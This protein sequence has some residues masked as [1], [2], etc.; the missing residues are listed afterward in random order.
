MFSRRGTQLDPGREKK[1]VAFT[2]VM[3]AVFLTGLKLG[4]GI[5]TG[6]LGI[7]SEAAHSGID[8]VAALLTYLAVRYSGKP[9][10][11]EH[12][13]GH[14]KIENLSALIETLLLVLTCIWIIYEA[15]HR[16]LFPKPVAANVYGFAVIFT[17]II[18]DFSRSRALSR[19]AKKYRSQ[20]LEADA[21]HFAS[22]IW[23]SLVVIVGLI[24]VK[25]GIPIGDPLAALVVAGMVIVICFRLGKKTVDVLLDRAPKGLV[26]E[27]SAAARKVPGVIDCQR[28]RVRSSGS[29][30]FL[31][32]NI[33]LERN[34][35]LLTAHEVASHVE[36]RISSIVPEADIM[37][38]VD[39]V[40][41]QQET[42]IDRIRTMA[43]EIPEIGE[44]HHILVHH[45][46][47][48]S[49][50]SL[51]IMVEGTRSIKE[52]HELA[53]KLEQRIKDSGNGHFE[54]NIQIEAIEDDGESERDVTRFSDSLVQEVK[55]IA[56]EESMVRDCHNIIIRK[57]GGKFSVSLHCTFNETLSVREVQ[58]VSDQIESRIKE[59]IRDVESVLVHAEPSP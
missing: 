2:S 13:Y 15:I 16:I 57:T 45:L 47:D 26:E 5:M 43:A 32:M 49:Y 23:S 21:L 7:L 8:I 22:D 11:E 39:P 34:T 42:L 40:A 51:H 30:S 18:V 50:V 58:K 31:D 44:V 38:H 19:T 17:S 54:I 4:V 59:R 55:G 6:S 14:G 41:G 20:A 1:L 28:I 46:K 25:L 33:M 9:P 24:F 10:D 12:L 3:A 48:K 36:R 53:S 35:P 29:K 52:A 37:I 56:S 27:I